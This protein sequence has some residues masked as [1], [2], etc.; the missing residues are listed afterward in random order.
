M[1]EATN[2]SEATKSPYWDGPS[3]VV[4]S[5]REIVPRRATR[6]LLESTDVVEIRTRRR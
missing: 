2:E 3:L 5:L 1:A 6:R 4:M